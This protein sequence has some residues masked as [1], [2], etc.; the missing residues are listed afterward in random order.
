VE[1]QIEED[2]MTGI[3]QSMH[4]RRPLACKEPAADFE[5]ACDVP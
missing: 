2:A 3:N 5:S 4:E 1:L